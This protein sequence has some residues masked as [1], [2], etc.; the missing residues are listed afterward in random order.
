[1]VTQPPTPPTPTPTSHTLNDLCY[2]TY[3]MSTREHRSGVRPIA[4]FL[5]VFL[6]KWRQTFG[7]KTFRNHA[8]STN[9]TDFKEPSWQRCLLIGLKCMPTDKIWICWQRIL[10]L[11][12]NSI[13][14]ASLIILR[15]DFVCKKFINFQQYRRASRRKRKLPQIQPPKTNHN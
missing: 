11:P 15:T 4:S 9:H 6:G 12:E 2:L 7:H 8:G 3:H 5:S 10:S 13:C 1:M 14:Y